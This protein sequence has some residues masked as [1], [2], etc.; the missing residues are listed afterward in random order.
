MVDIALE[1][2]HDT[3]QLIFESL[4][5]TGLD[6]S[7]ADLI[8]NYVLM[9]QPPKLQ[10]EIYAFAHEQIMHNW[11][12]IK[13]GMSFREFND[14]SLR[15]PEEYH[16][17]RYGVALHGG[18]RTPVL[19]PVC[20]AVA[21]EHVRHLQGTARH[22]PGAQTSAQA[23]C[24]AGQVLTG[25]GAFAIGGYSAHQEVNSSYPSSTTTWTIWVD[26]HDSVA[27]NINAFAL[28]TTPSST[29]VACA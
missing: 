2:D 27:H 9:G 1:K 6:L 4:N 21:A 17:N 11:S 5:S 22:G 28:C 15:I 10:K 18:Q 14:K 25:G 7:Q 8:R 16:E 12:I 29:G 24:P 23:A 19:L 13:P 3:P 26:N 20:L